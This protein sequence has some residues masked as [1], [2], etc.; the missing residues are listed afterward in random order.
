MLRLAE[1][2]V[3]IVLIS[4]GVA[5]VLY[6]DSVYSFVVLPG[7]IFLRGFIWR[8]GVRRG[9]VFVVLPFIPFALRHRGRRNLSRFGAHCH[10]V[11]RLMRWRWRKLPRR[12]RVALAVAIMPLFLLGG[13]AAVLCGGLLGAFAFLVPL[14]L[15]TSTFV[16]EWLQTRGLPFLARVAAAHGLHSLFV[17]FLAEI[18]PGGARVWIRHRY[19]RLWWATMRQ[20]I[21]DRKALGQRTAV[22]MKHRQRRIVEPSATC[23]PRSSG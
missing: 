12:Y 18:M 10:A 5:T 22:L 17:P 7:L 8:L 1:I 4:L 23:E 11:G 14:R 16:G 19:R 20:L 13:L 21:K 2:V 6:H 3:A 9:L 15:T